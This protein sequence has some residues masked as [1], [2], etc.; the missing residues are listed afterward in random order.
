MSTPDNE[1]RKLLLNNAFTISS[2][3][4]DRIDKKQKINPLYLKLFGLLHCTGHAKAK[5]TLLYQLVSTNNNSSGDNLESIF[6]KLCALASWE[7]F[8]IAQASDPSLDFYTP[9]DSA[10]LEEQVKDLLHS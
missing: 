4:K 3:E 9:S 2:Q 7:L 5:A 1:L 8:D 10:Q 6:N